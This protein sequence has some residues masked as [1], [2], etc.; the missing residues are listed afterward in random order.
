MKN[1][2]R[3]IVTYIF[4]NQNCYVITVIESTSI[5]DVLENM[6]LQH[7]DQA[8][9]FYVQAMLAGQLKQHILAKEVKCIAQLHFVLKLT[10][11]K[12]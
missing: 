10:Q 4:L 6:S 7:K 9:I 8:V 5:F 3:S 11:P 2:R 1:V 12:I